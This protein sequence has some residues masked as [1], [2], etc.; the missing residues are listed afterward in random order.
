[1]VAPDLLLRGRAVVDVVDFAQRAQSGNQLLLELRGLERKPLRA[2]VERSVHFDALL[3][4]AAG[5]DGAGFAA[6]FAAEAFFAAPAGL[7]LAGFSAAVRFGAAAAMPS[8]RRRTCR[9]SSAI[10]RC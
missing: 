8:R 7:A 2:D 1:A 3:F 6:C 9:S 5:F 10:L 4:F